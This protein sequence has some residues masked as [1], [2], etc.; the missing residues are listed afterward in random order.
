M[1]AARRDLDIVA[2]GPMNQYATNLL[3]STQND[4]AREL[5]NIAETANEL[6][7]ALAAIEAKGDE[8]TRE[9]GDIGLPRDELRAAIDRYSATAAD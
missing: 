1:A 9:L 6:R 4:E 8:L 2:T 3:R 5:R 7:I